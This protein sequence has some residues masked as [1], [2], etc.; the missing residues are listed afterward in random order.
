VDVQTCKEILAQCL[1]ELRLQSLKPITSGWDSY[2]LEV[3]GELIFRFPRR[4]EVE[5]GLEKEIRLLPELSR[6][7]SLPI[8]RFELIGRR[9]DGCPQPF[10]G[11]HKL[12]GVALAV[13]RLR[14]EEAVQV[15]RQLGR[16]LGELQRF[17]RPHA[18]RLGVAD[19]SAAQ[20]RQEYQALYAEVQRRAFPLLDTPLQARV[21]A[22][23]ED[24]LRQP[25]HFRF[26]AVL[27]H[28]D[29][30]A[31]HILYDPERGALSGVI[32][33]EDASIGDP[34]FDLTG[35]LAF[36]TGFL[37][38]VLAAYQGE[39]DETFLQRASFYA[40]IS[41]FHEILHGLSIGDERH[42]LAGIQ[43]L[44]KDLR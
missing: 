36:G 29:L 14:P 25:Q 27:L 40:R 39:V 32:D 28:R 11:Y 30:A 34:A 17:P 2:V 3:N 35:L 15:A 4:P 18:V 8:P 16:F 19:A 42:V 24:Y 7:L 22:L 12:P 23:W 1:P 26:R 10:V 20:W 5:A 38:Q 44:Q 9:S 37:Q 21:T 31:E 43:G 33:W 41:W 13:D 6:A